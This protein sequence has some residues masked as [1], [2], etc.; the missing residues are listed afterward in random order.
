MRGASRSFMRDIG[1]RKV[2]QFHPTNICDLI[3]Q[4][5]FTE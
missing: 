1:E 4:A 3:D 5:A 2:E